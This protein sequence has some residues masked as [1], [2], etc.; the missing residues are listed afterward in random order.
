M[1]RGP[2]KILLVDDHLLFRQAL[3]VL[4]ETR[5]EFEVVGEAENGRLAMELVSVKAPDVVLL[6]IVMPGPNGIE[7][8]R[9]IRAHHPR[10]EIVIVSGHHNEAYLREAFEA[11]VRGYLLKECAAEDLFLAIRHAARGDYFLAGVAGREMVEEY[12]RPILNLQ[13]PGGHITPR[14]RELAIL[15]S[16]GYST[17]EAASVLN[18]SPKTAETHRASIMKKLG[19]RNVAD[20]VKYCIRNHL[21]EP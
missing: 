7:T 8:A 19:A 17:K 18:I 1:P 4:L 10:T 21:V 13:K 6:D 12:V 11:G 15:L 14:E 20:I 2:L 9:W 16:D 3:R 5:G